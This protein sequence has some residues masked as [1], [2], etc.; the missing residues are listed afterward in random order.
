MK[1]LFFSLVHLNCPLFGPPTIAFIKRMFQP[2]FFCSFK[3]RVLH[4]S[5]LF[6]FYS[7][8]LDVSRGKDS[9]WYEFLT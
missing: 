3:L 9:H 2:L 7:V 4:P 5:F 6:I 8:K 1:H